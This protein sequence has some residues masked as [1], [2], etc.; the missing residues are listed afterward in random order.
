MAKPEAAMLDGDTSGFCLSTGEQT[1]YL[2]WYYPPEEWQPLAQWYTE[3]FRIFHRLF[4]HA[5][6]RSFYAT[7]NSGF[8]GTEVR[9]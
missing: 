4:E 5:S 1:V 6:Q 2:T 8:R 3:T 7:T 9:Y